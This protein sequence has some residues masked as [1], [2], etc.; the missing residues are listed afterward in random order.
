MEQGCNITIFFF[1]SSNSIFLFT[2]IWYI[3]TIK[4]DNDKMANRINYRTKGGIKMS[5]ISN[6][7]IILVALEFFYIMYLET[8]ATTSDSTS[9]IFNITK[10]ELKKS[11]VKTLFK[12]QGVYNGLIGL[13]LLYSVFYSPYSL[14]FSRLLLLYII[15]V[16][17]YGSLTSSKKII[18]T[19]GGL[20]IIA[21]VTTFF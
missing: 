6:I 9:R 11:S 18:F 14:E 19:Q 10:E 16:A 3:V 21:F 12:N 2:R 5:I 20:A 15:L 17:L 7:L 1:I 13:G 8:F 4:D